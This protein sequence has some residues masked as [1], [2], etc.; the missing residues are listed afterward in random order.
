MA[1]SL[2]IT[3]S[4]AF[5]A[6][7]AQENRTYRTVCY[8]EGWTHWRDEPNKFETNDIDSNLCT[9][10][11]WNHGELNST[12]NIV[13]HDNGDEDIYRSLTGLKS[14]APE[15]K[16][17]L[18]IGGW[19]VGSEEFTKIVATPAARQA[20]AD[21]AVAYLR[22]FN[23]DGTTMME[24]F[25]AEVTGSTTPRL[26]LVAGITANSWQIGQSFEVTEMA[27]T[28]DWLD[29]RAFDLHGPW[30]GALRH[31]STLF[32]PTA[33]T[34]DSIDHMIQLIV[35]DNVP[36]EKID[37]GIPL[38]GHTLTL[39]DPTNTDLGAPIANSQET[40]NYYEVRA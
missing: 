28:V 14:D 18:D 17:L 40:V 27:K 4:M 23:F 25:E 31:H 37:L 34:S 8:V 35:N 30:E 9:H 33:D 12:L 36:K 6:C 10:V 3:L 20:F 32:S 39:T 2:F 19:P 7:N 13:V 21:E 29:V 1:I 38:F 26:L 15:L 5:V 16:V 22:R 24:T 11:V